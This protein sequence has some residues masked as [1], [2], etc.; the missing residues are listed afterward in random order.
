M[1]EALLKKMQALK[2]VMEDASGFHDIVLERQ[3]VID[4]L[5]SQEGQNIEKK[6]EL[7]GKVQ[8]LDLSL[9]YHQ[10]KVEEF[11]AEVV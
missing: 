1:S 4:S 11:R 10:R 2:K 6:L 3:L 9:Q 7:R 5:W 8:Q